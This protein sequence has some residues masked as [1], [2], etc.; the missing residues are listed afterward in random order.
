MDEELERVSEKI[1]MRRHG[2]GRASESPGKSPNESHRFGFLLVPAVTLAFRA[3]SS[4][5]YFLQN[6]RREPEKP[7]TVLVK[8]I[9]ALEVPSEASTSGNYVKVPALDVK[10][11]LLLPL[12]FATIPKSI[13]C[14]IFHTNRAINQRTRKSCSWYKGAKI[15]ISKISVSIMVQSGFFLMSLSSTLCHVLSVNPNA[16]N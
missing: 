5:V 9:N 2:H 3:F 11:Q 10:R 6:S 15:G 7:L 16:M 13:R 4:A 12:S 14:H 1:V 8:S